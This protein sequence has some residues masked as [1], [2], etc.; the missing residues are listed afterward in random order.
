MRIGIDCRLWNESGVGRYIRNL[1]KNLQALDKDNTYVLFVLNKDYDNV[2]SIIHNSKFI[3]HKANI[4]WHTFSEQLLFPLLLV[5][6][7]LDLVHFPYFSVPILYSGKFVITIHDLIPLHFATGV[8]TTLPQIFYGLKRLGYKLVIR[9]ASD[10]AIGIITV[11]KAT[12]EEIIKHLNVDPDKVVVTYGG[13]DEKVSSIK[14][15]VSSIKGKYFLYVGNAYPHKNLERLLKAF[16]ILVSKYPNISLVLVGK[17]DYF[18]KRLKE[19]VKKKK[20]ENKVIFYGEAK[21]EDLA[22]LYKHAISLVVPSLMEG[23]GLPA[24]EAMVNNC[25]VLASDIAAL[26]EVCE[27]AAIYFNP[28]DIDDIKNKMEKALKENWDKNLKTGFTR[29][30]NFSWEKMAK[31]TLKVYIRLR[32]NS[33]AH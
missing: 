3:I 20:L 29:A 5:R 25:L 7:K 12:K 4:R 9:K 27:E 14:Q 32:I 1:V 33:Q 10:K 11:S 28:Y 6:E 31:Q 15:Q 24:L 23:F 30:K 8:A 17:E 16:S 26:R 21:D 22:P 2:K 18:Y 13:V 19:K